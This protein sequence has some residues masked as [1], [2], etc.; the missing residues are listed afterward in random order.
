MIS[1]ARQGKGGDLE[2]RYA[3]VFGDPIAHSLSPAMHNAAFRALGLPYAYLKF[4]VPL[5]ELGAAL[6]GIAA[7]GFEGVNLTI[8]LKEEGA[9][10]MDSLSPQAKKIGAV[11]TVVVRN[12]RLEGHNTDAL[13]FLRSVS[14]EWKFRV[15][16]ARVAMLGTGG[17]ARA[18]CFALAGAGARHI[19]LLGILPGQMKRL[20]RDLCDRSAVNVSADLL[21]RGFRFD[22]ALEGV[23]L[24]VNA[25]P[26][27]M[28]G[29]ASPVPASAMRSP[30]K[31][32][33]LVYNPAVTGLI[34]AARGRGLGAINGVGMLVHQGALAFE[35]WTRR[36][37]PVPV[38]R[39]ALLAGLR[40]AKRPG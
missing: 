11:N 25:T 36:A 39:R 9:R 1:R 14:E 7:M 16:G 32:V 35:L 5:V 4:R 40:G 22:R 37:A 12:G 31:V 3:A 19:S 23:D 33:D 6:K 21:G 29:E 2:T 26:V 15:R 30:L 28:K 18:I 20:K 34:A 27:G 10:L 24:L 38:M 8:P 17:A 13:G